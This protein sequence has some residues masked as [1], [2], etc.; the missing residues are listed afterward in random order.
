MLSEGGTAVDA[1]FDGLNYYVRFSFFADAKQSSG[2]FIVMKEQ[3]V[4][5]SEYMDLRIPDKAFIK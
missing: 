3:G 4:S 5:P 2:A 1:R